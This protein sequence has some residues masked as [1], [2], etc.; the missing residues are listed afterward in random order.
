MP[1]Q[2]E[3]GT[4]D[5]ESIL[6]P[7][8]LRAY[9]H[10]AILDNEF[11]PMNGASLKGVNPYSLGFNHQRKKFEAWRR[12]KELGAFNLQQYGDY[13]DCDCGQCRGLGT[14]DQYDTYNRT[15]TASC[16]KS[17]MLYGVANTRHRAPDTE[18]SCGFYA[19]YAPGTDFY[20][21][22]NWTFRAGAD[23]YNLQSAKLIMVKA[24]VE[25]SGKVIMGT[26]GVRAEKM[27]I[28]AATVDWHK[29]REVESVRPVV[30]Y[31][32]GHW[33]PSGSWY[34]DYWSECYE[35]RLVMRSPESG[36]VA[37]IVEATEL[38][39]Y[40]YKIEMWGDDRAMFH[41]YPQPDLSSLLGNEGDVL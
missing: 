25:M 2:T 26:K 34:P 27:K 5:D 18:C 23:I 28:I 21:D 41:H 4:K 9:R 40:D 8:T 20:P 22:S 36:T 12:Y 30:D 29:Y 14:T 38:A 32:S 7:S 24:V 31:L 10:F 19:H 13:Y 39:C 1:D 35:P 11:H 3:Y 15:F 17:E 33:T 16:R 37:E 6:V